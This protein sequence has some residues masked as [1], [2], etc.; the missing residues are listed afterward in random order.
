[1]LKRHCLTGLKSLVKFF[2]SVGRTR[3]PIDA[4][5]VEAVHLHVLQ[6]HLQHHGHRVL[7]VDQ[8]THSHPEVLTSGLFIVLQIHSNKVKR[9][10]MTPPLGLIHANSQYHQAVLNVITVKPTFL[11]EKVEQSVVILQRHFL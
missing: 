1:M 7:I 4:L 9:R 11:A 3:L 5:C 8:V 10:F 2:H 6:H